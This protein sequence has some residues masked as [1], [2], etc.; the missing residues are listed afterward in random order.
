[1]QQWKQNILP[2]N[3]GLVKEREKAIGQYFEQPTVQIWSYLA[4]REK[5]YSRI[6]TTTNKIFDLCVLQLLFMIV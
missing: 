2:T 4:T 1:M 6:C 5:K 3:K